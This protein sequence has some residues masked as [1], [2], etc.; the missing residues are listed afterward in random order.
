MNNRL[1]LRRIKSGSN[2]DADYQAVLDLA[3]ANS[4][5]LPSSGQQILQNQLVLDLKSAGVWSK[6][7]V[8]AVFAHDADK[9]FSLI[10]WKR[11]SLMTY[12]NASGMTQSTTGLKTDTQN[13]SVIDTNYN[14]VL[15][16]VNISTTSI[17]M[18]IWLNDLIGLNRE[19]GNSTGSLKLQFSN[20]DNRILTGSSTFR[21]GPVIGLNHINRSSA[22][23]VEHYTNGVEARSAILPTEPIT[24]NNAF[25]FHAQASVIGP[26]SGAEQSFAFYAG[27]LS[28]EHSDFYNALNNYKIAI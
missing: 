11:A 9:N 4:F 19:I 18:G 10:D 15:D 7:D 25:I 1:L 17:S 5:V 6:L 16:A 24:N 28:L 12:A 2:F 14:P 27:D 26:A 13:N 23:N 21:E 3:N 22:N 20:N 8:F